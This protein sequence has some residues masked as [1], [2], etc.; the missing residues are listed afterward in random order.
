MIG[1]VFMMVGIRF[2]VEY[3]VLCA[4]YQWRDGRVPRLRVCLASSLS[5]VYAYCC[6]QP[7][8][9]FLGNT[10]WAIAMI[11]LVSLIAFGIRDGALIRSGAYA[12]ICLVLGGLAEGLRDADFWTGTLCAAIVLL[13]ILLRSDDAGRGRYASVIIE[14]HGRHIALMAL[15]DTGN[16][17]RDPVTG[18][19]VLIVDPQAARDL[20]GLTAKQLTDPVGTLTTGNY[21]GMRLIPYSALGTSCSLLLAIRV[22]KLVVDGEIVNQIVA[23]APCS[24]GEGQG[25]RALAGGGV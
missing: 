2:A 25:F 6:L 3:L 20:L 16:L 12:F 22:D 19:N 9:H 24:L 4:V 13:A 21:P 14:H 15:R 17:L 23:F 18:L 5:A 10:L 7:D 11:A 1:L 8:L